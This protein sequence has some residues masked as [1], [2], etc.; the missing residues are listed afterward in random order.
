MSLAKYSHYRQ[1]VKSCIIVNAKM[2]IIFELRN[3]VML[4][5]PCKKTQIWFRLSALVSRGQY[6]NHFILDRSE[7]EN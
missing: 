1:P 2:S 7:V 4:R 6:F 3:V 5:M